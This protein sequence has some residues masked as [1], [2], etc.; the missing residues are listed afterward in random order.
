[1]EIRKKE[2]E[3]RG[4]EGNESEKRERVLCTNRSFQK[5][6]PVRSTI[7]CSVLS[8]VFNTLHSLK[9]QSQKQHQSSPYVAK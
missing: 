4:K 5:S 8:M 9:L 1:V 7:W 2:G 3:E 6:A